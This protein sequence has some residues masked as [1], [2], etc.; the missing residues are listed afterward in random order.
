M[1]KITIKTEE[2]KPFSVTAWHL[3]YIGELASDDMLHKMIHDTLY[4]PRA[5][6]LL[7]EL[8]TELQKRKKEN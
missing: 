5:I 8:I 3:E 2:P 6:D 1:S 7:A 4:D